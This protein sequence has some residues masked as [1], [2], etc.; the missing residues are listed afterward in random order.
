MFSFGQQVNNTP[1][2]GVVST[3]ST[4]TSHTHGEFRST[5][6]AQASQVTVQSSFNTPQPAT[7]EHRCKTFELNQQHYQERGIL[8]EFNQDYLNHAHN[9]GSA[10]VNHTPGVNEISIIF[11][12][13]YNPNN[14][15]ENVSNAQIMQ[16]YNDL[17]EDYL[18]LNADAA[19]ARGGFGF[20]PANPGINFCLATQDPFGTPLTEVGV[21]R[22]ST[23]EDWYDSD[24]GEENKMKSSATGGSDPWDRNDYLNVWICDISNGAGSGTAGYAYRPTPTYLPSAAID[25]IVLDYNLGV[26]NDNVLTHEVG[27]YLGLDHTWGGSGGC[28]NDDGFG[29]TPQTAGPSFDYPG[30]CS[31]S[32]QTC[33][34]TETQYENYMDY[35]NCTVM[36]T[37]NQADYMLTILQGIRSSLLLSPGCDPVDAPPVV[38]FVADQTIVPVGGSVSFTSLATN[39]PNSWTWDF[40]GGAPASTLENPNITFNTVGLY[41]VTHTATNAFGTGSETKP[42]YI[43]VVA[44]A[45]GTGCDTL[46]NYVPSDS[47][48]TLYGATGYIQGN[49]NISGFDVLE[50]AEPYTVLATTEVRRLEFVPTRVSD[51]GGEIYFR[52]YADNAGA[53]GTVLVEDTAQ[54][55]DLN[56]LAWNEFDF[57]NPV[58]VT[59]NFWVGY[60]VSYVNPTD[61]FALLTT[62]NLAP[63]PNPNNFTYMNVDLNGWFAVSDIYGDGMGNDVG[64]AFIMDVLTSNGP[65]PV[66]TFTA[67]GDMVCEGG[68]ITVNG[69]GSTNVTNYYWYVTDDP[70]TTVYESSN[71]AANTF[72][73]PTAGNEQIFLFADGSCK[74][75]GV[76]MPVTINVAPSAT[77]TP[78]ATTCGYNNGT[79]DVTSP[80]GGD[81]TTYYY[82]LD[83]NNYQTTG[84]FS[85]LPAGTYDVYVATVGDMCETVYSGIVVGSSTEF[86]ASA[87]GN[88]SVCPGESATLVASGGVSYIWTDGAT[89]VGTNSSEVVSPSVTTQYGCLVTDASGC[90][91]TVYQTVAVNT[92]PTAPTISA[93]GSTTICSGTSVDLTSSYPTN[94]EW[95]TTE[96][97]STITVNTAGAY[98]VTYT[99]ANGCTSTS[100]PT[101]VT[102]TSGA[103]ITS[104]TV[105]GPSAC[106]TATGSIEVT[107]SATGDVSWTGTASGSATGVTLPYTITNLAAG[108]YT[109][110]LVDGNGCTSN[111]LVEVLSDPTPPTTPTIS[112]SGTTTFCTGGMVTLTSSYGTGNTWSNSSTTASIDV[113]TTGTYTVTYT[114]GSGCSA[115][116]APVSVTVNPLPATPTITA[117]GPITFCDG[118][119]VTLTSSQGTGNEWSTTETT[120][121]ITATTS[122]NYTVTYTNAN[123]CSATSAAT[124]VTVN[125]LPAA[126]TITAGGPTTFCDGGSVTLTSSQASGNLWSTTETTQAITVSTSGTFTVD[127]TDGNGCSS[128]SAPTTVTVNALPTVDAGADQS[129]CDGDAVTVNGSGAMTYVWDNGVTDGVPFTPTATI[130]LGC[131]GTDA[132]GC[133]N[134]DQLTITVNALPNVTMAPLSQVCVY[135][136]PVTLTGG[137]PAGGSYSGTGVSTGDFDPNAA[138][139]GTHTI[140]YTY[141]D[142]NGCANSAATDIVVDSCLAITD[143]DMKSLN[144]YPNPAT[145]E[146]T[147]E[148][149]ANFKYEI[150]DARGRLV[151]HGDASQKAKLNIESFDAGV[152]FLNIIDESDLRIIR[153]VKQ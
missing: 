15:A 89:V 135:N 3:G 12:V 93:S 148:F 19:N 118:G 66:A 11:H 74:T 32:Q 33:G 28:T 4:N 16:V 133:S 97:S 105:A 100:A 45:S 104:G 128:S 80:A 101:V 108:S 64:T 150:T 13:V 144:V 6:P 29:D 62:Y 68:D 110:Q 47:W 77:V 51:G 138:G 27:H 107:G 39:A 109:I 149:E 106:A 67:T 111:Q 42:D 56:E 90:Q 40:G 81:G 122:G 46:R 139:V 119:S 59:G 132:N 41:T 69:S 103:T 141:S 1:A 34:S 37:Q 84:T 18:L 49:E 76:Y 22:V 9:I 73:F 152:Y 50:W 21:V 26:N 147:I 92:P 43:Q 79:I 98:T 5:Q 117:G 143:I 129:V 151:L 60:E 7:G 25:G 116:S 23:T 55:A 78:T 53:P 88:V 114:D 72:N 8:N 102:V 112:T 61:T 31:G 130:T 136:S 87:A 91:S 140:T 127:Y 48:Y 44:P 82:S 113:T 96:T 36:F 131:T 20:T 14:P 86:I 145:N 83:G 126:P 120:Q 85:N 75:D 123:G 58:S 95:S 121:A 153:V 71:T 52:V 54:L 2:T 38:D 125:P 142:G 115:T 63:T 99:D 24:N 124:T 30:S 17:V 94:N 57:T 134:T 65:D 10:N 70:F 137:S 35:A 146:L